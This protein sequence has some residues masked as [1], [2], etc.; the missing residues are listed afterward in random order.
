MEWLTI[1]EV[2]HFEQVEY[3]TIIVRCKRGQYQTIRTERSEGGG[4]DR[5]YI[6]LSCLSDK[7]R[8]RYRAH[9]NYVKNIKPKK[10]ERR[11]DGYI[12]WY[13][14]ADFDK[15]QHKYP[16]KVSKAIIRAG[17]LDEYI[18]EKP[19]YGEDT[20]RYTEIFAREKLGV[21]SV[22]LHQLLKEYEQARKLAEIYLEETGTDPWRD[23][24]I[25]CL[26]P[27]TQQGKGSVITEVMERIIKKIWSDEAFHRHNMSKKLLYK[28]F[29]EECE[30]LGTEHI[31]SYRTVLRYVDKF[32]ACHKDV[33]V[34]L[35]S[36]ERGFK[37]TAMIKAHRDM[38]QLEVMELVMADAHTF[39]C[40]VAVADESGELYSIRPYLS[41]L[42][43]ARSRYIVGYAICIQP[44]AEVFK[45]VLINMAE[46][47]GSVPKHLYIDNGKEY[48]AHTLTGRSRKQRFCFDSDINGF[49]KQFGIVED[50]R[51]LPYQPWSKG[52]IERVFGTICGQFS[53]RFES[54]TG[55]LTGEKTD[56]KV[57][58]D[59][60]GMLKKGRL[61]LISDF[62]VMFEEYVKEYHKTTHRGL[63]KQ[64]EA[65]PTPE[66]VFSDAPRYYRAAPPLDYLI[67]LLGKTEIRTV[68]NDGIALNGFRYIHEKL[69]AYIECKVT[70]RYHKS[71]PESI[72]VYDMNGG[73]ICTA[74]KAE[75]I[76]PI[77]EADNDLLTEHI[78]RQ[79][80][81]LRAVKSDV[82]DMQSGYRELGVIMPELPEEK[83]KVVAI[84]KD[85][86]YAA[87]ARRNAAERP[88]TEEHKELSP[89]MRK[90]A[91]EAFRKIQEAR[92]AKKYKTV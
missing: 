16:D 28:L 26:C 46:R 9:K 41:A 69:G 62:A 89:Y 88:K 19:P 81:Q 21:T 86:E 76:S 44:N 1:E 27:E 58:K 60:P 2:A 12:P 47:I 66:A 22:R 54:Y 39:D 6:E 32:E 30:R 36:G 65:Q 71:H 73:E 48:T 78:K 83:R 42:I 64:K 17:L 68:H 40:W 29:R 18:S 92:D 67:S 63:A 8:V 51:A 84:P 50:K 31:P 37:N 77:A 38:S 55:T 23:Y 15:Y 53:K 35:K 34:Y 20:A 52:Q 10:H 13:Y 4:R 5:V 70:V 3:N 59:I 33:A 82:A 57:Q 25:L 87:N 45:E 91:D 85:K 24:R 49:Y 90:H 75:D 74:F 61:P 43:D 79:K 80:R 56:G 11:E 14:D 72:A 7:A